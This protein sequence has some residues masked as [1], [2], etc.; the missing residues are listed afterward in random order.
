MVGQ[1]LDDLI[2]VQCSSNGLGCSNRVVCVPLANPLG[3]DRTFE[4]ITITCDDR[5]FEDAPRQRTREILWW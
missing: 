3:D 5:I 2:R 4:R 1:L